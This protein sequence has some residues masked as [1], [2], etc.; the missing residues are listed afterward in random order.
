MSQPTSL[1]TV[2]LEKLLSQVEKPARYLGGEWNQSRKPWDQAKLRVAL[3]FPDVYEIGM[4]YLGYQILYELINETPDFLAQRCYSPR[5]DMEALLRHEQ[6]PLFTVE[7]QRPLAAFDVVGIT[8]QHEM[9]YTNVLN[10]LDLGQLTLEREARKENH[11]VVIGGGPCSFNPEPIEPVFD[12]LVLGDGEGVMLEI[13]EWLKTHPNLDRREKIKQLGLL[14]GVYAPGHYQVH[15]SDSGKLTSITADEGFAL[16]VKRRVEPPQARPRRPL[17]PFVA[18]IHDRVTTQLFR[19]CTRGCRFCQ[20]GMTTRPVREMDPEV[21]RDHLI[22][23][24]QASGYEE[25]SLTSLS[26]GDYS[27]LLP[28]VKQLVDYGR[29]HDVAL[30]LP[31]LRLD[32]FEPSLAQYIRQVRKTGLT[33]APEAGSTRLRQVINKGLDEDDFVQRL[34]QVFQEGWDL[35]KL[36]FMIGLP[37]ESDEDIDAISQLVRRILKTAN[38]QPG[39]PKSR[40][41]SA[42][43]NLGINL[44]IPKPHTPFQWEPQLDRATALQRLSRVEAQMP[45]AAGFRLGKRVQEELD[46]SYLEAVLARGDRRLWPVIKQAWI[47]GAT[48]DSWGDLF[49]FSKWQQAFSET[50][51][52]PD[53]YVLQARALEDRLPWDHL[54]SGVSKAFLKRELERARQGLLTPDCCRE[55]HCQT[56]GSAKEQDCPLPPA[57]PMTE[58]P[59]LRHRPPRPERPVLRIRLSYEKNDVIRFIGHLDMVNTWRR[60]ARRAGLP[61]HYSQGF[62]PQPA[63]GFGPPLPL[64]YRGFQEWMDIGLDAAMAQADVVTRFNDCLPSGLKVLQA[65]AIALS[66]PSLNELVNGGE[67]T[68][69][70]L[71]DSDEQALII[72]KIESFWSRTEV[73]LPQWSKKGTVTVNARV[74]VLKLEAANPGPDVLELTLLHQSGLQGGVKVPTLMTYLTQDLSRSWAMDVVRSKTGRLQQ[75][76]LLMPLDNDH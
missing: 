13:L 55:Q 1:P 64:G 62:H 2:V 26:S 74:G 57:R 24:L 22:S 21:S 37:T 42:R 10:L 46:R 58:T 14:P 19:G 12:L 49:D 71:T 65:Y 17:V 67:Y 20:A 51:I 15:Y 34:G 18:P 56:C 59:D 44:F 23:A 28:L 3:A 54:D 69:R 38:Q 45:K 35:V 66:T 5:R 7:E 16:P 70:L 4:S 72:K 40:K 53:T 32:S 68:I 29:R 6:L 30:S 27:Q 43:V 33:F 52:D 11:P 76:N 73:P 41:R 25:A 39:A 60:A 31:S 50:G 75:Q 48:F 63:I 8:L 61:V 9:A 36:Y 47:L